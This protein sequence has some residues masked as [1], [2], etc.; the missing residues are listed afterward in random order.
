MTAK[1][2]NYTPEAT[3]ELKALFAAGTTVKELAA[4][5]ARTERSIV[6]KLSREGVYTAKAKVK[7]EARVKKEDL[8]ARIAKA[9][10]VDED[11]V[12]SLE[13]ATATALTLVANALEPAVEAE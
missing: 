13:K 5:F 7:A 3:V 1:T 4:K 6:A 8:V 2:Q 11:T 12:G 10:N 9:L